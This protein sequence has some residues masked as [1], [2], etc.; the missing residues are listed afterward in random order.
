MRHER[1]RFPAVR[2]ATAARSTALGTRPSWDNRCIL[3]RVSF[4]K[5]PMLLR[6]IMIMIILIKKQ[7]DLSTILSPKYR[8]TWATVGLFGKQLLD[9]PSA[10]RSKRKTR[11]HIA[12]VVGRGSSLCRPA[13][14][15]HYKSVSTKTSHRM[16]AILRSVSTSASRRV[17]G[18]CRPVQRYGLGKSFGPFKPTPVKL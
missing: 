18:R 15:P 13:A 8:C 11:P 14:Q 16:E 7:P 4:R 3:R 12:G 2:L 17:E 1:P 10:E 6:T 9:R 5:C